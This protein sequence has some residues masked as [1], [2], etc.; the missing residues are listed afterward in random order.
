MLAQRDSHVIIS[1]SS[2]KNNCYRAR[3]VNEYFIGSGGVVFADYNVSITLAHS[4]FDGCNN[5]ASGELDNGRVVHNG[6]SGGINRGGVVYADNGIYLK[7][8]YCQFIN[9]MAQ[10]SGGALYLKANSISSGYNLLLLLEANSVVIE[11]MKVEVYALK[12][13]HLLFITARLTTI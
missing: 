7:I 2:F 5:G 4:Y 3:T 9:N 1:R 11:P 13:V 10:F 6:G 8:T 12:E